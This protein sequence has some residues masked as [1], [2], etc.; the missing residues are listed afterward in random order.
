M[1]TNAIGDALT[2]FVTAPIRTQTYKRSAYLLLVFGGPITER[3]L[4]AGRE[5]LTYD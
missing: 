4:Q 3:H 5:G 1:E 2:R